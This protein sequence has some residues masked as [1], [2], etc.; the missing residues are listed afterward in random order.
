MYLRANA[1]IIKA[2]KSRRIYW[3][4]SK[5]KVRETRYTSGASTSVDNYDCRILPTPPFPFK[6]NINIASVQLEK[7][8][9]SFFPDKIVIIQ[10]GCVAAVS[11]DNLK[12]EYEEIKFIEDK[13]PSDTKILEMTWRYVNKDGSRDRR[14][15]NNYQCPI[16]AYGKLTLT[17][18]KALNLVLYFSNRK[19][20][21]V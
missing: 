11:Y 18:G 13:A 17:A 3:V 12:C 5:S 4:K 20:F 7:D 16:C 8:S 10:D 15:K 9:V 19:P 1:G 2:S 14:F 6:T 21:E